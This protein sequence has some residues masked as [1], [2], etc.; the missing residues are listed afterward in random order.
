MRVPGGCGAGGRASPRLLAGPPGGSACTYLLP[1]DD[2]GWVCVPSLASR[3]HH[4]NRCRHTPKPPD[5]HTTPTITYTHLT[6]RNVTGGRRTAW[7]AA[8]DNIVAGAGEGAATPPRPSRR[9]E[10]GVALAARV[11]PRLERIPRVRPWHRGGGPGC[12][13]CVT[14]SLRQHLGAAREAAECATLLTDSPVW[15]PR[16]PGHLALARIATQFKSDAATVAGR[17]PRSPTA[18]GAHWLVQTESGRRCAPRLAGVRP[19]M[20]SRTTGRPS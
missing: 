20:G 17:G 10:G 14:A 6:S 1:Q 11:T 12:Q 3:P 19:P 2:G 16:V 4:H 8:D 13:R 9:G 18:P 5:A 7:V 15:R